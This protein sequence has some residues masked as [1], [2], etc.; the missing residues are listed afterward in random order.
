[1]GWTTVRVNGWMWGGSRL[2]TNGGV[3]I[4]SCLLPIIS[5]LIG[6]GTCP[7]QSATWPRAMDR[8]RKR[9]VPLCYPVI[10]PRCEVTLTSHI[11]C[12]YSPYKNSNFHDLEKTVVKVEC[13][14]R[15]TLSSKVQCKGSKP[16]AQ[17][18]E[19]EG[20]ILGK[21]QRATLPSS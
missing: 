9:L 16:E 11:V 19:S 13:I 3:R 18:A 17:R 4:F 1:M 21:G 2:P 7:P 15:G 20:G 14:S 10:R 8:W 6:P 12:I 5:V